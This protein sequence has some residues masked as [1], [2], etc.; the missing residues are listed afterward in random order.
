MR[1]YSATMSRLS[2]DADWE[3]RGDPGQWAPPAAFSEIEQRGFRDGVDGAQRDWDNHRRP[4]P[5]N[6]DEYREPRVPPQ[7]WP[8][9]REGFRR[10]YEMMAARLWGSR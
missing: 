6:R 2:G 10:G 5:A 4:N 8:G 9:Y 7:F 1:G 3:N